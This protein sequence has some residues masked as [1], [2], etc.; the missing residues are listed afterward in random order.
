MRSRG[1]QVRVARGTAAAELPG[2]DGDQ[3]GHR[4]PGQCEHDEAALEAPVPLGWP[5]AH[6]PCPD[7]RV[8]LLPE[9]EARVVL[10]DVELAVQAEIVGIRMQEPPHIRLRGQD[11]EL[12]VL[13]RAQVLAADLGGLLGLPEVQPLAD[14]CLS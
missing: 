14:S 1:R 13:E 9:R 6:P 5:D 11:V 7:R 8:V 10:V 2:G 12:L 4:D 3:R